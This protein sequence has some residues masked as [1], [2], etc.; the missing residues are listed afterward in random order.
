VL[1]CD[2]MPDLQTF[3]CSA[4]VDRPYA[5]VRA[6]FHRL[7]RSGAAARPFGVE[8]VVEAHDVAG[9]PAHTR[10][11][12]S[13]HEET[14]PD[15]PQITA[16]E[17]RASSV[18]PT[19]TRIEIDGHWADIAGHGPDAL[20]NKTFAER[21]VRELLEKLVETFRQGVGGPDEDSRAG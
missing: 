21:H 20:S 1:L 5:W 6:A 7:Q 19:A 18:S 3:H 8:R 14:R 13:L 10:A 17:V 4:H 16:A 9:L 2:G 11:I 15:A 12:L